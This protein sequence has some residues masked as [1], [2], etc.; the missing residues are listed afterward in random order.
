MRISLT[1]GIFTR[2]FLTP[3]TRKIITFFQSLFFLPSVESSLSTSSHFCTCKTNTSC[4]ASYAARIECKNKRLG[5]SSTCIWCVRHLTESCRS[6]VKTLD[7]CVF[8]TSKHISSGFLCSHRGLVPLT[9]PHELTKLPFMHML[10]QVVSLLKVTPRK[11]Q[12]S[13]TVLSLLFFL[14]PDRF[15]TQNKQ[16]KKKDLKNMQHVKSH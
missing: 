7:L 8:A 16:E 6:P 13:I 4:I 15:G 3:N 12:M 2:S 11:K 1:E 14:R 10:H 9:S 5:I